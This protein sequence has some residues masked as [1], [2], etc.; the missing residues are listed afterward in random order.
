M[1]LFSLLEITIVMKYIYAIILE[2]K[3]KKDCDIWK[4]E[5]VFGE[6]SILEANLQQLSANIFDTKDRNFMY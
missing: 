5:H 1:G 4:H 6:L 3:V 2:W